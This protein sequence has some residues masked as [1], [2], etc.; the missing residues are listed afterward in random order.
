[1]IVTALIG[2]SN[3]DA[4]CGTG[5]SLDREAYVSLGCDFSAILR[6]A[7]GIQ[8]QPL[9]FASQPEACSTEKNNAAQS[10]ASGLFN[11]PH[12]L[13][14]DAT[15][16][17][18]TVLTEKNVCRKDCRPTEIFM[19]YLGEA[20]EDVGL[21]Y[22]RPQD[23]IEVPGYGR[24][25][26]VVQEIFS[27]TFG[28]EPAS[29]K[30]TGFLAQQA[31]RMHLS[32]QV[33]AAVVHQAPAD[34]IDRP[35]QLSGVSGVRIFQVEAIDA[36]EKGMHVIHD[37]NRLTVTLEPDGLGKMDIN[38]SLDKGALHAQLQVSDEA[39]KN[40]LEGNI[41]QILD[42]LT[43]EGLNVAG[44]SVSLR[45]RGGER[46]MAEEA[47]TGRIYEGQEKRHSAE[48]ALSGGDGIVNI[49]V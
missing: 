26:H 16:E 7:L 46:N 6:L 21:T 17:S 14:T 44:F 30:D 33:H 2:A 11:E 31:D 23:Y 38:L 3:F 4:A 40:L 39:A 49:F 19:S 20:S 22:S 10:S 37:G 9:L 36:F 27:P 8:A 42:T 15:C 45:D 24:V 5:N 13:N 35:A 48:R 43:R 41:S 18:P 32:S 1:M 29:V 47:Y 34:L 12:G 28:I 25:A